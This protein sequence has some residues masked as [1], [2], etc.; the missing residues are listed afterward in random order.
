MPAALEAILIKMMAK[1]PNDRYQD[2]KEVVQALADCVPVAASEQVAKPAPPRALATAGTAQSVKAGATGPQAQ[3]TRTASLPPGP[4]TPKPRK[5][6]NPESDAASIETKEIYADA[7]TARPKSR[8]KQVRPTF[9]KSKNG[10]LLIA[11]GA[12]ALVL[13]V[14]LIIWVMKG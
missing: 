14:A 7:D 13:F 8:P 9:A 10:R 5:R 6:A 3:T 1:D 12:I 2:P 11:G 4:G